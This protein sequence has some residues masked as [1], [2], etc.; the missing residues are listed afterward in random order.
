[1]NMKGRELTMVRIYL[2]E[3]EVQLNKLLKR[4]HDWEKLRG[5]TVFRGISGF[6]SNGEI[7]SA[8]LIDLAME[9]PVV[10]EFFDENDKVQ[11]TLEHL[12]DEIKTGHVVWWPVQTNE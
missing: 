6:G 7:H 8:G 12:Q 1:M 5:L 3:G 4:L 10:V 9:L 11:A 2:L